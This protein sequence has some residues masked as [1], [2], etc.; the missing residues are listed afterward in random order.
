MDQVQDNLSQAREE[1]LKTRKELVEKND[2]IYQVKLDRDEVESKF[3]R[4]RET[5]DTLETSN[6][7]L[8]TEKESRES[9][10][11]ELTKNRNELSKNYEVSTI[12]LK[13]LKE[14]FAT[15]E[16]DL[17]DANE[18]LTQFEGKATV[19]EEEQLKFDQQISEMQ[20]QLSKSNS[21]FEY[22]KKILSKDVKFKTLIFLDSIG[23]EVRLDNLSKGISVPQ[24]T[25]QRAIIEL[26]ESG[27]ANFRK[28]GRFVYVSK[29]AHESPFSLEAAFA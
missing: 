25:V 11:A 3:K 6:T 2:E 7:Q 16:T 24:E 27:F 17:T 19:T 29:G 18:R 1:L 22:F 23:E 14:R 26:S 8:L 15:I 9:E 5:M 12:E 20:Q 13:G 4:Q 21:T 28:E 10:V